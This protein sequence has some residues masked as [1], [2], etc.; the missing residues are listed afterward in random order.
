MKTFTNPWLCV[1]LWGI[2]TAAS[3]KKECAYDHL[4]PPTLTGNNTFGC[5]INGKCW[6][7]E[8]YAGFATAINVPAVTG[9]FLPDPISN[10]VHFYVIA[11]KPYIEEM[12]LFIRN[13]TSEKY[14]LPGVYPIN[15][16]TFSLK[17]ASS[18]N[19][20]EVKDYG[21]YNLTSTDSSHTGWIEIIKLDTINRIISGR[22][23][24]DIPGCSIT[25]GRFDTKN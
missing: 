25:E 8:G 3:C 10:K 6:V 11:K 23:E 22:F 21:A 24:F 13:L 9:G 1:L 14:L 12:E 5:K 16:N 2:L 7:A 18:N 15:K 4:P 20:H 19:S 17:F